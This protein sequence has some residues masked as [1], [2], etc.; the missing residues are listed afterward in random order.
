[1]RRTNHILNKTI[2]D[3]LGRVVL[4]KEV[5]EKLNIDTEDNVMLEIT[6]EAIMLTK[7]NNDCIFCAR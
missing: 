4:P 3:E 2:I 1:M 6:E 7:V 5:R